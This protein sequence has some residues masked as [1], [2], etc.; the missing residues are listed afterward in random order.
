M[1]GAGVGVLVVEEVESLSLCWGFWETEDVSEKS[2]SKFCHTSYF[3][4]RG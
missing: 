4:K 3:G 2:S 1:N